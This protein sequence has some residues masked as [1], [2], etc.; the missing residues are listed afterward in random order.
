MKRRVRTEKVYQIIIETLVTVMQERYLNGN[1]WTSIT[2]NPEHACRPM[3]NFYTD[4]QEL[5][6]VKIDR[7]EID[8]QL[9][10]KTIVEALR[11]KLKQYP[12]FLIKRKV[13]EID[14][15]ELK[16]S[17]LDCLRPTAYCLALPE[18]LLPKKE[19]TPDRPLAMDKMINTNL[20]CWI[21]MLAILDNLRDADD[22]WVII[23]TSKAG[24]NAENVIWDDMST[25]DLVD[26]F[27]NSWQRKW[28]AAMKQLDL[29]N[30]D[31]QV[32]TMLALA[33]ELK[34]AEYETAS[35]VMGDDCQSSCRAHRALVLDEDIDQVMEKIVEIVERKIKGCAVDDLIDELFHLCPVSRNY[36]TGQLPEIKDEDEP[37]PTAPKTTTTILKKKPDK[38]E[39]APAKTAT[40]MSV[41]DFFGF[42]LH[43]FFELS[44]EEDEREAEKIADQVQKMSV[45]M[46][47]IIRNQQTVIVELKK[48]KTILEVLAN[49]KDA[50][51]PMRKMAADLAKEKETVK[52]LNQ[53]LICLRRQKGCE[54]S[55]S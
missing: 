37:K 27:E 18:N 17:G 21:T 15:T 54:K 55:G 10:N 22:D 46:I 19:L 12:D 45:D 40:K 47:K 11:K 24:A 25:K 35:K 36:E 31:G 44:A 23:P 6:Q 30:Y 33:R 28:F 41:E 5:V 9:R 1:R 38:A 52:S 51:D 4:F 7:S 29:M 20:Q 50:T 2:T 53:E 34:L 26:I 8:Y 43:K 42:V 16:A 49:Y 13:K 39:L 48:S 32:G 14:Q 3:K